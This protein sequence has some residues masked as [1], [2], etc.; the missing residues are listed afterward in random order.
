MGIGV[1]LRNDA[2]SSNSAVLIHIGD[3]RAEGGKH[4]D[5]VVKLTRQRMRS[6]N[7][8]NE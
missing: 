7:W 4:V 2:A 8:P 6:A 1:I 5:H 3:R